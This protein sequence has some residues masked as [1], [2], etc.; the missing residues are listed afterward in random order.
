M[1]TMDTPFPSLFLTMSGSIPKND[2]PADEVVF[3]GSSSCRKRDPS[4]SPIPILSQA[5]VPS[6]RQ[7][8]P[9]GVAG[10]WAS[11]VE[12][13]G[14]S[15]RQS[16]AQSPI[17]QYVLDST[18]GCESRNVLKPWLGGSSTPLVS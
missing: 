11:G 3:T 10:R 16:G 15:K 9:Q 18:N 5:E 12:S 7:A 4:E 6:A 14:V 2:P 8:P 17:F 1:V 13:H